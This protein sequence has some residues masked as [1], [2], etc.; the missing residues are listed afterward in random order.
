MNQNS[1]KNTF[2]FLVNKINAYNRQESRAIVYALMEYSLG[3]SKID[4]LCDKPLSS[5]PDFTNMIERLNRHEPLQYIL[6]NAFFLGNSFKVNKNVLIP[7]PETEELVNAV[8]EHRK[9]YLDRDSRINILDIGTGSGCIAVSL[10][11]SLPNDGVF[12]FDISEDA[13][14]I[15]EENAQLLEAKVIFE[16][17]D[18]LA[19]KA[20]EYPITFDIIVSNPPYV[21]ESEKQE[22]EANVLEYE[23]SLALFVEDH[24]ALKF[25]EAIADFATINLRSQGCIWFEINEYLAREMQELM[26]EKGFSEVR[27]IQDIHGKKRIL[28]AKFCEN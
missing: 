15:A 11:K 8:I 2:E 3:I 18:I 25:Y 10:A 9:H 7:R 19:Q 16:K 28:F 27:I 24:D 20:M 4:I 14:A 1:S 22:M 26:L 5:V 23:P 13:L 17:F 12:A 6:G 21:R